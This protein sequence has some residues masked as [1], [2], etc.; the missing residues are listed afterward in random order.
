MEALSKQTGQLLIYSSREQQSRTED[1]QYGYE[2]T[3][4]YKNID[5]QF[6]SLCSKVKLVRSF[7]QVWM[8]S[9]AINDKSF[10]TTFVKTKWPLY[11]E[12]VL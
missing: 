4:L 11:M 3:K 5:K 10:A 9:N 7:E 8:I 2:S 12:E 1:R 6:Y